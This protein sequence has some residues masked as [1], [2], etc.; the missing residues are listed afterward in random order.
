MTH[1]NG[2]AVPLP[3]PHGNA[4]PKLMPTEHIN[5]RTHLEDRSFWA[6]IEAHFSVLRAP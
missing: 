4:I 5:V 1:P 6:T 2:R 3:G